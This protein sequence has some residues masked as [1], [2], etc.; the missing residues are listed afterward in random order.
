MESEAQRMISIS[1]L[2]TILWSSVLVIDY[3]VTYL[4]VLTDVP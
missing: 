2:K 4:V 3:N 1:F